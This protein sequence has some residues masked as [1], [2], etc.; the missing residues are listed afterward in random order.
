MVKFL[1]HDYAES[2]VGSL[3]DEV[4]YENAPAYVDPISGAPM[5]IDTYNHLGGGSTG[6]AL[7]DTYTGIDHFRLSNHGGVFASFR[8]PGVASTINEIWVTGG[9]GNDVFY[10]GVETTEINHFDGGGRPES[11]ALNPQGNTLSYAFASSAVTFSVDSSAPKTGA[12]AYDTWVDIQ[13][14]EGSVYGDTLYSIDD[15]V[16]HLLIGDPSAGYHLGSATGADTLVGATTLLH[17]MPD[18]SLPYD[19]FIPEGG[20]DTIILG[21]RGNWIDYENDPHTG[22]IVVDLLNASLNTGD[23]EGD[24]YKTVGGGAITS[25]TNNTVD[26][27]LSGS[28][29]GDS[30]YGTDGK[31]H[32]LGDP[33]AGLNYSA[34]GNDTIHGRGGDDILDGIGGADALYGDDGAD[35]IY[36][37]LGADALWGG[38]GADTFAYHNTLLDSTASG[39]DII[40]DFDSGVDRI[41]LS[42]VTAITN[43]SLVSSGGGTFLFS[44]AVGGDYLQIGSTAPIQGSNLVLG[45]GVTTVNM[46]GDATFN[47]L[48]A[49]ALNDTIKGGGAGDWLAGGAGTDRFIYEAASD[50]TVANPDSIFDFQQGVEKLDVSALH[51]GASDINW[52]T[53][54]GSTYVFIDVNHDTVNDMLIQLNGTPSLSLGDFLL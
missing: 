31:N 45:A 53:S 22:G 46:V 54:S 24:T 10:S 33:L 13:T 14:I 36:G 49:S 52:L 11:T 17:M 6:W 15:G 19:T 47:V 48:V 29:W 39:Y 43:V 21:A 40:H 41:D 25:T 7:G 3:G 2:F 9:A 18:G 32:I 26:V 42:A 35:L 50:S 37:G 4:S 28:N 38:A 30:L 16:G 27:S 34:D 8:T 5:T 12:A 23:A 51:L 44:N 20:A 1:A